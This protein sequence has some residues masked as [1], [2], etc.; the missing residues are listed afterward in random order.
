MAQPITDYA[1]FLAEAKQAV[2]Q[3]NWKKQ[4]LAK[5]ETEQ[6]QAEKQLESEQKAV[7]NNV[8]STIKRREEEITF[9]YDKE[10]AKGQDKLKRAKAKREKAKS[11]GIRDRISEETAGLRSTNKELKLKLKTLVTQNQAPFFCKSPIYYA[12]YMPRTPKEFLFLLLLLVLAFAAL[13]AGLYGLINPEVRSVWMLIVIYLVTIVLVGGSYLALGNYTKMN[14][15]A[16]VK[17]GRGILNAANLN[18]KDI[19]AITRRIKRDRSDSHY[20]LE[21]YDDEIAQTE[22]ELM[23]IATKKQEALNTFHT[24]TQTIIADEIISSSKDRID[25]LAEDKE[26]T[27]ARLKDMD[28]QVKDL[29][30]EITDK[31]EIYLGKEFM[32]PDRLADLARFIRNGQAANLTEAIELYK[33]GGTRS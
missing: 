13:P 11:Q 32:Q 3:L 10:I 14:Y 22:Q 28:T 26:R 8:S 6:K 12:L 20:H 4:S 23:Q 21:V 27:E 7:E 30:L 19:K 31:Y 29:S 15:S 2:E 25:Q 33:T 5:L 16:V 9:S 1:A 24:V 17:A 18:K